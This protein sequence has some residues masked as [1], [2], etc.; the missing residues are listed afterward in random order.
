MSRIPAIKSI[1]TPFPHFI[2]W[3]QPV[4]AA[5]E[6][7][8][9]WDIRHLPVKKQGRLVSVISER[10]IRLA[11]RDKGDSDRVG[12]FCSLGAYVV[13][14]SEPLDTVLAHMSQHHVHC[15]VVVKEERLAGIFTVSDACRAFRE[16]L[17]SHY[18]REGGDEAA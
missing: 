9:A 10:D 16:L 4:A 12:D 1:M 13:D 8:R 17:H 6:M 18:G 5:L 3:E 11:R 7:M 2:E 15:V 14:L